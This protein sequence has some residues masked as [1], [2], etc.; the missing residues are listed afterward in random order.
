MR[1]M[2]RASKVQRGPYPLHL[3]QSPSFC[4]AKAQRRELHDELAVQH[5]L[6]QPQYSLW[7]PHLIS[8]ILFKHLPQSLTTY[9]LPVTTTPQSVER[10]REVRRERERDNGGRGEAKWSRWMYSD[11]ILPTSFH[12]SLYHWRLFYYYLRYTF[13]F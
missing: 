4:S 10:E 11:S 2:F 6:F 3:S 5:C 7:H 8:T 12:L 9:Q 13:A 1:K